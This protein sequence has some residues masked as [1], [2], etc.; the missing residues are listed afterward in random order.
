ML[1]AVAE[2]AATLTNPLTAGL[3][4]VA[5][6]TLTRA[7]QARLAAAAIGTL[8]AAPQ[9]VQ[10]LEPVRGVL[11]LLAAI[12]ACLLQ[13]E[14]YLHLVLPAWRLAR[15]L[16][17]WLLLWVRVILVRVLAIARAPER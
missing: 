16:T 11:V 5:A 6:C 9:L 12:A 7:I 4:L 1:E 14:L 2:F 10:G 13:A 17:V 8:M 3:V 15:A